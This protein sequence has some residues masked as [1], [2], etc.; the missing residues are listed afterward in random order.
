MPAENFEPSDIKDCRGKKCFQISIA[1]T[2]GGRRNQ[3]LP[4]ADLVLCRD[5]LMH[6]G[7]DEIVSALR[8]LRSTGAS[9]AMITT[10]AAS[11][12]NA[13]I[14][15]GGWWPMNLELAPFF[16]PPPMEVFVENPPD[17]EAGQ[18][19]KSLALWPCEALPC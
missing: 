8:N 2:P 19:G 7:F 16:L 13:N 12:R 17:E 4:K 18:L 15:R 3:P 6:L 14:G 5:C 11:R 1:A 10:F 9:Y